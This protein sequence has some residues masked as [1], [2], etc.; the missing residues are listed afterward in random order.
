MTN[1]SEYKIKRFPYLSYSNHLIENFSIIGYSEIHILEIIKN[2]EKEIEEV[3]NDKNRK[4]KNIEC[5]SFEESKINLKP[6]LLSSIS[7]DF[8]SKK[9]IDYDLIIKA[10]FPSLPP[11]YYS[12]NDNKDLNPPSYYVLFYLNKNIEKNKEIPINVLS[13]VFFESFPVM[14]NTFKIY[15][16]KSFIIISQYSYF[17]EYTNIFEKVFQLFKGNSQEIP[18]EII[19]YNIINFTPIPINYELLLSLFPDREL[20]SYYSND[21]NYSEKNAKEKKNS[22]PEGN[23]KKLS[24]YPFFYFE[25]E[26]LF[27]RLSIDNIIKILIFHF[28]ESKMIFFGHEL[29]ILN[30]IMYSISK[31][32]YPCDNSFYISSIFSISKNEFLNNDLKYINKLNCQFFGVNT[33]FKTDFLQV[34]YDYYSNYFIVDLDQDTFKYY[35]KDDKLIKLFNFIEKILSEKKTNSFFLEKSIRPLLG[36]FKELSN[37]ITNSSFIET[38]NKNNTT[39]FSNDIQSL[40][41]NRFIQEK[42]YDFITNILSIFHNCKLNIHTIEKEKIE[43]NEYFL[44]KD[45]TKDNYEK[46]TEEERI[47]FD[48]FMKTDKGKKY[49][50]DF[51]LNNKFNEINLIPFI[52]CEEFITAKQAGK[53]II[54]NYFDIIDNFYQKKK[55]DLKEVDF[56]NFYKYY[57]KNLKEYFLNE[58]K[59]SKN[60]RIDN[61]NNS[62]KL[63]VKYKYKVTDLNKN[64]LMA[65][66]NFLENLDTSEL[67]NLFPSIELLNTND[68]KEVKI[69]DLTQNIQDYFIN[70]KMINSEENLYF[71]CLYLLILSCENQNISKP[72]IHVINNL[73]KQVFCLRRFLNLM[74]SIM[75]RLC[76]KNKTI[77][78]IKKCLINYSYIMKYLME[79]NIQP[80]S[81]LWYLMEYFQKLEYEYNSHNSE[82]PFQSTTIL[83]FEDISINQSEKLKFKSFLK[84]NFCK[85][86]TL[87]CDFFIKLSE[88]IDR[89]SNLFEECKKCNYKIYPQICIKNLGKI[90]KKYISQLFSPKKIFEN[91]KLM[92]K[93]YYITLE[94]STLKNDIENNIIN[95]LFYTNYYKL[96]PVLQNY[97]FSLLE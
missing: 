30:F 92:V 54:K 6:I 24:G 18:L 58:A 84:Y 22:K 63:K 25:L 42:I 87:N 86:G 14:N 79:N 55:K 85:D 27:Q 46:W 16:P 8:Y 59:L 77:D 21:V 80:D 20:L 1:F 47:F 15:I 32:N 3:F 67:M 56:T 51:L 19:L 93:K 12:K 89:S 10:T 91:C 61:N 62:G 4:I 29:D 64:I 68:F 39:F 69:Y 74:L 97:L 43:V 65:Y 13:F 34:I 66:I 26:E 31:L 17:F 81:H 49:I 70:Q 72:I 90:S 7:S 52:F 82:T 53:N 35:G 44:K 41:I 76:L 78:N 11:I 95:L 23:F 88:K 36:E 37:K 50:V 60:F 40:S 94:R 48:L 71:I 73:K 38:N 96:N 9:L 57:E 5:K 83:N 28:L 2:T 45:D 33:E 75:Y